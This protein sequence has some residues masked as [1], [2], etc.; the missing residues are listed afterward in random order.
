MLHGIPLVLFGVNSC[1]RL[2]IWKKKLFS[3]NYSP[4]IVLGAGIKAINKTDKN[5]NKKLCYHRAY[6]LQLTKLVKYL[7][8]V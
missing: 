1:I 6:N 5:K 3:I 7:L 2:F 4:D 8:K